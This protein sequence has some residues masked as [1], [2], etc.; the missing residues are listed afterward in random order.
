MPAPR[1]QA[2]EKEIAHRSR[3]FWVSPQTRHAV[4]IWISVICVARSIGGS[5]RLLAQLHF[6][7]EVHLG[8]RC[9]HPTTSEAPPL[10]PTRPPYAR[11]LPAAVPRLPGSRLIRL[12]AALRDN[13]DPV[14]LGANGSVVTWI[15][16]GAHSS[17]SRRG[18][19]PRAAP[20]SEVRLV[21]S[22]CHTR[23]RPPTWSALP[24]MTLAV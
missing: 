11:L 1:Q 21:M 17:R 4:Q 20:S 2:T 14:V 6:S 15:G 13:A 8:R 18:A 3:S 9:Y 22:T 10:A 5:L 16:S 24:L 19:R 7:G 12:A 23:V